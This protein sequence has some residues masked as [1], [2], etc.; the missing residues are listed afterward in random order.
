M[1]LSA[2]INGKQHNG[3]LCVRDDGTVRLY[4]EGHGVITADKGAAQNNKS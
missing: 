2:D 3:L 4:I 1:T